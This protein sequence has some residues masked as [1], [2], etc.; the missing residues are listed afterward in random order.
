MG[1]SR[2]LHG[3]R[4]LGKTTHLANRRAGEH[5]KAHIRR[6]GIARKPQI[7]LTPEQAKRDGLARTHRDAIEQHLALAP[8]ECRH[9]I[10]IAR[11]G[12]TTCND[13]IALSRGAMHQLGNRLL[14][15]GRNTVE[16]R[17]G[18]CI[19]RLGH[20]RR[21]VRVANLPT[22]RHVTRCDQLR[23]QRDDAHAR[24]GMYLHAR[25]SGACQ[26]TRARR[27]HDLAGVHDN[28]AGMGLLGGRANVLPHLGRRR[29]ANVRA[30]VAI[31]VEHV[32]DL[33]FHHGIGTLGHRRA[34]HDAD[35]LAH[36][37]RAL[38]DMARGLMSDNVERHRRLARC[39]RQVR[40]A[41][42]ISV[43]SAVGKRRDV[44]IGHR[45]LG[46]GKTSRLPHGNLDEIGRSN[47]RQN[48]RL[49]VLQRN[50]FLCHMHLLMPRRTSRAP[51]LYV[52][53]SIIPRRTTAARP[54][55]TNTPVGNGRRNRTETNLPVC[56]V[57]HVL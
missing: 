26:Q 19:E 18:S 35:R 49:R 41:H 45:V 33:V 34:R 22:R 13:K 4:P 12:A 17:L 30:L 20:Q 52:Y 54:M 36:A 1:K 46:Q 16:H 10:V 15:V 3:T 44:D 32:D 43:H 24:G 9:E 39:L 11:R 53:L 14:I 31:A 50:E 5:L 6:R 25:V 51:I 29:E 55:P 7:R 28:I 27:S 38:K 8:D 56:L 21:R 48:N 2:S 57:C 23:A 40:R 47:V 37:D 42:G